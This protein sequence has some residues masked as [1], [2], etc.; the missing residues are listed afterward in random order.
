[1]F[2]QPKAINCKEPPNIIPSF[3]CP[4]TNPINVQATSGWWNSNSSKIPSIPAKKAT[5]IINIIVIADIISSYFNS[6]FALFKIVSKFSGE[7]EGTLRTSNFT[8]K[9][10]NFSNV[11]TSS[12]PIAIAFVQTALPCE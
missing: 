5:T 9:D 4:L 11:S 1:M 3:K 2:A 7:S 10:F 8:P 6:D 12:F